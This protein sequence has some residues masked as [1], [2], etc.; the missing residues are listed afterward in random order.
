MQHFSDRGHDPVAE[1]IDRK[2]PTGERD[3]VLD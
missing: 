2:D 3:E 1:E